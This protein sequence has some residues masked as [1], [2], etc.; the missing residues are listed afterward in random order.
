MVVP[1]G[2]TFPFLEGRKERSKGFITHFV[3]AWRIPWTEELHG[4]QSI[5]LQGR[6]QLRAHSRTQGESSDFPN[7]FSKLLLTPSWPELFHKGTSSCRRDW[8][9]TE[10]L[11]F[12]SLL[13]RKAKER[14]MGNN[15]K[16]TYSTC[17]VDKVNWLPKY[18]LHLPFSVPFCIAEAGKLK[19]TFP[20]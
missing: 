14:G 17:M 13:Q 10:S 9:L 8:E 3:L 2:S 4:L 11:S 16:S 12:Q 15:G 20:N 1:P 5:A 18:S 6:T 19:T 7:P